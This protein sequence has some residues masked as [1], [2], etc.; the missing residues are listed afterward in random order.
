MEDNVKWLLDARLMD[1]SKLRGWDYFKEARGADNSAT[2][3]AV[4]GLWAGKQ[5]GVKMIPR[6]GSPFETTTSVT[7]IQ[8]EAGHTAAAA[9]IR[10]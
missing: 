2:H 10:V 1:G 4:L 3:F 6:Y 9:R 7:R 5:A 8:R